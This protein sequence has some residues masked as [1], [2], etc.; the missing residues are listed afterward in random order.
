MLPNINKLSDDLSRRTM[1]QS[2]AGMTLGLSASIPNAFSASSASTPTA[3]RK[4]VVRIFLPGGMTHLDSFDPKPQSPDIMGGTKVV[5]TN[6]GEEI[7]AF[8]PEMA[9]RMDKIA[10][11]RSMTSSEGDHQRGR[12]LLETSY[13]LLG[14]I[15][16]PNFGA[17]MQALNGQQ[18]DALPASVHIRTGYDAGFLGSSYDPFRV[19]DPKNPLRGLVMDNPKSEESIELLKLMAEVRTDFHKDYKFE[20]VEAYRKYYNES[21]KLMHSDDLVAFDLEKEDKASRAKF[22]IPHGDTM[23]LARRLLEADVQYISMNIGGWDD[24]ND[25]W[26]EMNYPRKAKDLDKALATFLDD[27]YE[28]GLL[29]NTIVSVNTEF[30]RTPRISSRV[31]RD[32]HRKCFFGILAGAGVNTGTIYGK[33]DDKAMKVVENPVTPVNFNATLAQLAGLSLTKE[34]YSPDNRPFTVARG[35]KTVPALIA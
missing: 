17:W 10:L 35:G 14:T 11:V 27:L 15:K 29:E 6:T 12:Y 4:K 30:G 23:L 34:L 8:F 9:K 2:I 13:P 24:H 18:N 20:G 25:L 31:G 33:T 22:K 21:I 5:K 1:M 19:N 28:R 32:H 16:H 3:G 7:S 26:N